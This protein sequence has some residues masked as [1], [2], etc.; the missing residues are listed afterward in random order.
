MPVDA[1]RTTSSAVP[2]AT[3]THRSGRKTLKRACAYT[4]SADGSMMAPTLPTALAAVE[5]LYKGSLKEFRTRY[6]AAKLGLWDR[7]FPQGNRHVHWRCVEMGSTGRGA[8][9]GPD[10]VHG[11]PAWTD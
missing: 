9:R 8:C 7:I 11:E 5:A 1:P 10:R 3:V 4:I 6:K 2:E